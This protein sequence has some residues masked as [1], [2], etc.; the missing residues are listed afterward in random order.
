MNKASR[1][2]VGK[3]GE[4]IRLKIK[5]ARKLYGEIHRTAWGRAIPA[6]ACYVSLCK[7]C[8]FVHIFDAV[9]WV[10]RWR[11]MPDFQYHSSH[12][13]YVLIRLRH[14]VHRV[15]SIL[16]V[17]KFLVP[18]SRKI[19]NQN[20]PYDAQCVLACP[21]SFSSTSSTA[22]TSRGIHGVQFSSNPSCAAIA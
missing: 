6:S 7:P 4:A 16:I 5:V 17:R 2:F 12:S 13:G 21:R 14:L 9:F 11:A 19:C 3:R 18:G 10:M 8:Q 1:S 15:G 20:S 22:E